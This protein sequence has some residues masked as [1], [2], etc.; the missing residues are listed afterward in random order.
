[1]KKLYLVSLPLFILSVSICG[2]LFLSSDAGRFNH[3]VHTSEGLSCKLCHTTASSDVRAGMPKD[4]KCVHCHTK[5]Y[6]GKPIE[7]IYTLI[8]WQSTRGSGLDIFDDVKF[9]HS[10][11]INHLICSE[12]HK[13]V[14]NSKKIKTEHIPN[15]NTC[16]KCHSKW[17]NQELCSKCHIETR[18]NTPPDD[19]K[20]SNFMLVHGKT[21]NDKPFD[22]WEEGTGRH[23]HLCFQCH[24][25]D[26]CI[27]C[28]NEVAPRDHTNQWRLIGHGILA[29]IDR[30]RCKTCHKVDFCFRCHDEMRPRSHVANWGA[31]RSMHCAYCHEPLSSTNCIVCHKSTPSHDNAPNAPDFVNESFRCRL[32]HFTV[33]PL[34]HFDNG[35]DCQNCHFVSTPAP[36]INK[37]RRRWRRRR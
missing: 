10:E 8:K 19:H 22:N 15:A 18:I 9:S 16:T 17:L 30:G 7:E 35:E 3:K 6:N 4:S 27:K 25:Q 26:H 21:L 13:D 33:V 23:S 36:S 12:C 31:N 34:D 11:H 28:H 29:G 37:V 5:V 2:C 1:M 20:R 32:C 24:K 14:A